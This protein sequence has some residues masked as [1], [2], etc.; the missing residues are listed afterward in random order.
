MSQ[1]MVLCGSAARGTSELNEVFQHVFTGGEFEMEVIVE[2]S[3]D[4]GSDGFDIQ[5]ERVGISKDENS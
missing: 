3:E 1:S 4:Q 5:V 2:T